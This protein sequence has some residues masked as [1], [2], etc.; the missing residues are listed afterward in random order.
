M[1]NIDDA[2]RLAKV[3]YP[4]GRIQK[5]VEYRDLFVFQIFSDLPG[6]E[7]MDP[8]FSV[9][10]NTG[11]FKDFSIFTDADPEEITALFTKT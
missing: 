9:D 10:R 7:E 11:E 1:L 5:H 8:Y 4:A 2:T 3:A 6:E